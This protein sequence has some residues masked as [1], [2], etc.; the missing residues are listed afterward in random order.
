ML[1]VLHLRT[2]YTSV[3]SCKS[4]R[5]V[6]L[7]RVFLLRVLESDFPGDSLYNSTDMSTGIRVKHRGVR[8]H[9]ILDFKVYYSNSIPQTFD[10][11]SDLS[12]GSVPDL[13]LTHTYSVHF[14]VQIY[15]F[16]PCK[17]KH[18]QCPM[19]PPEP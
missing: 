19:T 15:T 2:C 17:Q 4:I 14:L 18:C 10:E 11:V 8:F 12:D 7:L 5:P 13:I 6:H 9:Q 3:R 1:V 16:K